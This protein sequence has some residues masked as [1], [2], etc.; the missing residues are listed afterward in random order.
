MGSGEIE[1]HTRIF[2]L[3]VKASWPCFQPVTGASVVQF[4]ARCRTVH[5]SI[6]QISRKAFAHLLLVRD[7]LLPG[8][9]LFRGG[10]S[11]A[12]SSSTSRRNTGS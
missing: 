9:S 7:G 11:F 10:Q 8:D 12:S 4:A 1:P 2:G 3:W 5:T 6:T